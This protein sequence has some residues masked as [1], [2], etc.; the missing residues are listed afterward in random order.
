M[1]LTIIPSGREKKAKVDTQRVYRIAGEPIR[2][3][4]YT[5]V[6]KYLGIRFDG[7]MPNNNTV[8]NDLRILPA[9]LART[10][11]KPQQRLVAL[12]CYLLPRPIHRLV[13]GPI[14]AKLLKALDKIVRASVRTWLSLPHDVSIGFLYVPIPVGGLGLMCLRFSIPYMKTY[15]VD[16]LLYSDH[17]QCT[18]AVTK[19]FIRKALRQAQNLTQF[20][21]DVF[22]SV[23]AARKY[24]TRNLHSNFDGRPLSQC[25][26]ASGS[27]AWLG[28]GTTFL[29]GIEFIDLANFHIAT[30]SN[31][32]CL[33]WPVHLTTQSRW[34]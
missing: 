22:G 18:V 8:R 31:L 34:L 28:E 1:T 16:R 13:L 17:Y 5:I 27:M 11:L 4:F 21:G 20:G 26:T 29:K 14:S 24:W 12:R 30:I 9:H 2:N 19:D 32:T 33:T 3:I 10:A 25:P 7:T 23:A 15:R 6:W